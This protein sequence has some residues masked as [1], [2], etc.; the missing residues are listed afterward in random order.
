[1]NPG[2]TSKA[3]AV[4]EKVF[5]RLLAAYPQAHREEYGA[6][7]AQLFRDQC[8]D[9]WSESRG[10]GLVKL[11]LRVL[12]DVVRTSFLEHLESIKERKFMLNRIGAL[13]RSAQTYKFFTV[14]TAVFLLVVTTATVVTFILPETYRGTATINI[15][16]ESP[17]A[18]GSNRDSNRGFSNVDPYFLMTEFE[19]I[20]SHYVLGKVMENPKLNLKE[21]WAVKFNG[22]KPLSTQEAINLLRH[23][24]DLRPVRGTSLIY[25]H[26]Y[27]DTPDEA[28]QIA[29]AVARA[30][31][32]YRYQLAADKAGPEGLA[33]QPVEI[34]NMANP[35]PIPV[36]PNK[37][38]NILI[39]IILGT[40]LG[41]LAGGSAVGISLWR[42][43]TVPPKLSQS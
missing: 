12:P 9:A 3:V 1:M 26:A 7:M 20:Q 17:K 11:W 40:V 34:L 36:R 5:R 15:Q 30:Y 10:W 33:D 31:C 8:R 27:R 2:D 32:D 35:N 29:N 13:F 39:G 25:I 28:A 22:G 16:C 24:I 42:R 18:S 38:L 37:P 19:V 14:F 4:S 43:Q 6:A 41:L 23:F 21:K